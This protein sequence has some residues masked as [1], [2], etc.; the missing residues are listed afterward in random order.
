MEPLEVCPTSGDSSK[1]GRFT[2]RGHENVFTKLEMARRAHYIATS[3]G[4]HRAL[5]DARANAFAF[6]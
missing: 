1:P 6:L 3:G 5:H 4:E 2:R